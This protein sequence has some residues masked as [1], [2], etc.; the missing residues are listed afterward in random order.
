MYYLYFVFVFYVL[1][2]CVHYPYAQAYLV[3]HRQTTSK[4]SAAGRRGYAKRNLVFNALSNQLLRQKVSER[5]IK[6][7]LIENYLVAIVMSKIWCNRFFV[8]LTLPLT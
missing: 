2:I 7:V 5:A 4:C 6:R 3:S 8:I 1:F